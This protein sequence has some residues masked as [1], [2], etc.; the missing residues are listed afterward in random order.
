MILFYIAGVILVV[1]CIGLKFALAALI[2]LKKEKTLV[3][4]KTMKFSEI[5]QFL[6]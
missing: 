3:C 2:Q 4:L 5:Q 1:S 6:M